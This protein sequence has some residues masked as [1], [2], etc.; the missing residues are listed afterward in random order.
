MASK[1]R[2][3]W[4]AHCWCRASSRSS[5]RSANVA[6]IS[7]STW[8]RRRP[9]AVASGDTREA[10]PLNS[11]VEDGAAGRYGIRHRL[12]EDVDAGRIERGKPARLHGRPLPMDDMRVE[13]A[14]RCPVAHP[15]PCCC[16]ATSQGL[17]SGATHV[18]PCSCVP[19]HVGTTKTIGA[20]S[21]RRRV[22]FGPSARR[23]SRG[24]YR[25]SVA[26]PFWPSENRKQKH[27][28]KDGGQF[29][30]TW[31]MAVTTPKFPPPPRQRPEQ[32]LFYAIFGRHDAPRP[33]A[34]PPRPAGCRARGRSGR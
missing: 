7:T 27:P 18:S 13:Y 5:D 1:A 32:F 25:R 12:D 34:R 22:P 16:R 17:S 6:K 24:S 9:K 4:R 23:A 30:Q 11:W 28:R 31:R 29:V 8:S 19:H 15:R 26:G 33:R 14:Q 20:P 2:N 10:A 3:V 21:D